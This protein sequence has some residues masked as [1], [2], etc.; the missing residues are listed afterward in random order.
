[1]STGEEF[2]LGG[3]TRCW[4][5]AERRSWLVDTSR[6]HGGY[7]WHYWK[8][9]VRFAMM[10]IFPGYRRRRWLNNDEWEAHVNDPDREEPP[11]G[12]WSKSWFG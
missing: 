3:N 7:G 11:K 6:P 4:Y 5:D 1:M 10:R 8:M 2:K 9:S 12:D